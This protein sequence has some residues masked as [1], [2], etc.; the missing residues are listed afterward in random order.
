MKKIP[1]YNKYRQ[2]V[3]YT[4]VDDVDYPQ[5][6]RH[7]WTL[8]R[9]PRTNYAWRAERRGGRSGKLINI[10]MH[11][12]LMGL[13][14]GKDPIVDHIDRDGLN[15]KRSNLRLCTWAENQRNRRGWSKHGVKGVKPVYGG[16][17]VG[18]IRLNGRLYRLG[19][20]ETIEEAHAAYCVA[21]K[22]LHGEF[23]HVG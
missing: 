5:L 7:L 18:Q 17:W 8:R 15:N 4:E 1:L 6:S 10:A 2:V 14:P 13:D 21:A 16:K 9:S 11:R 23:A 3:G 12:V 20:F 19:K 22:R